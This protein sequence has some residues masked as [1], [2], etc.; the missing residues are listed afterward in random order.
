MSLFKDL[1]KRVLTA[2]LGFILILALLIYGDLW[3][4]KIVVGV[5]TLGMTLELT[6]IIYSLP[7]R[8]AKRRLTVISAALYLILTGL[9]LPF[10]AV[11]LSGLFVFISSFYLFWARKYIGPLLM[12]HTQELMNTIFGLF[13]VTFLPSL[14]NLIRILPDGLHWVF[15]FLFII[16]GGDT[17]AYFVGVKCGRHKIYPHISPKKS[18]E[19]ALGGLII[20]ILIALVYRQYFNMPVSTKN[21]IALAI[22]IGTVAQI[23]DFFESMFKRAFDKKDSGSL[24][25]GHGGFLDRFDGVVFALPVM[26]AYLVVIFPRL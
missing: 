14:F 11:C 9:S 10:F 3:G 24:L 26:Y 17:G 16:W 21:I 5:I 1:P 13:Y 22:V 8:K 18:V 2:L 23:G 19:G 25:P 7:D 20:G 6:Q 4:L 12:T 15:L